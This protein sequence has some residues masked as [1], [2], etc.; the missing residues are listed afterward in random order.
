MSI[1]YSICNDNMYVY[2]LLHS[3]MKKLLI[4]ET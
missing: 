2:L 1:G 3:D 4:Y